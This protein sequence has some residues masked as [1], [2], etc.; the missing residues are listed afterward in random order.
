MGQETVDL[1]PKELG[2]VLGVNGRT[3]RK[4]AKAGK[5]PH[6]CVGRQIRFTPEHVERIRSGRTDLGAFRP[7]RVPLPTGPV[8]ADE[9]P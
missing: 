5:L 9:L 2:A 1:G 7:A 3:I 6:Y 8:A 4:L